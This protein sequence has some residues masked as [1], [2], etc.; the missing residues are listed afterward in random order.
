M[1]ESAQRQLHEYFVLNFKEDMK[2]LYAVWL[3]SIAFMFAAVPIQ[4]HVPWISAVA[5]GWSVFLAIKR[6]D[7]HKHK[8]DCACHE[9]AGKAIALAV[10]VNAKEMSHA[11]GENC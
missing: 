5:V 2:A 9:C 1:G 11:H 4:F 8:K 6:G 7:S 3:P 10:A